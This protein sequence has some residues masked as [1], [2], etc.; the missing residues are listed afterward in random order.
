[1]RFE[2]AI[3]GRLDDY[4]ESRV[5]LAKSGM[6]KAAA[7]AGRTVVGRLRADVLSAGLG[8]RIANT[9]R[10]NVHPSRGASSLRPTVYIYSKEPQIV[11]AFETGPTIRARKGGVY[12]WVPTENVPRLGR[13]RMTP[14]DVENR[15]NTDFDIVP[16]LTRPGVYYA[17]M[18]L[19][20]AK[21]GRGY[22]RASTGRTRAGR[23]AER[24]VMFV[25]V[26]QVRLRKRTDVAGIVV[27]AQREW[28]DIVARSLAEAFRNSEGS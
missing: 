14:E 15:F 1:M 16:A 10:A 2:A 13:K 7:L 20:R 24:V 12:L 11:E 26:R 3:D 6:M 21:S 19:V 22:R 8:P 9:W 28:T 27:T 4:M 18:T 5:A 23:Q 17:L 25:L